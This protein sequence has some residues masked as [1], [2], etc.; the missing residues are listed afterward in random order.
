MC[1]RS[2]YSEVYPETEVDQT[3]S[4]RTEFEGAACNTAYYA[5]AVLGRERLVI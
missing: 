4:L 1:D 3:Y 2:K 5:V